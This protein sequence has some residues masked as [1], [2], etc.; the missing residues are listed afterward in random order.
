[1]AFGRPILSRI[2]GYATKTRHLV[3][4]RRER[5]GDDDFERMVHMQKMTL[6]T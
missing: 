1:M 5:K 3:A 6:S 2:N 4:L